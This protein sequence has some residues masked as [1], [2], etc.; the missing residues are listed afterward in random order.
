MTAASLPSAPKIKG[1]EF[2]LRRQTGVNPITGGGY[3]GATIGAAVWYASVETL[4]L[5]RAQA[6]EYAWLFANRRGSLRALY[7]YDASRP[8]PLAFHS[9]AWLDAPTCDSTEVTCDTDWITCDAEG[10]GVI[11]PWGTPRVVAVDGDAGTVDLEGFYPGAVISEGDYGAWDDGAT[12]R[13]H[14]THAGT[15][16]AAGALTLSVE[17]APPASSANLPAGFLM[18][19]ACAE[20]LLV[21]T[22]LAFSAPVT[23]RAAFEAIQV[24]RS[25]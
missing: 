18:E 8:R 22:S 6:G 2:S 7:I 21:R 24:L 13:L 4:E 15:A 17:A 1:G 11:A 25:Q 3:Q 23:S 16:N 19:K 10:D 12:R 14:I 9:A 5:S 20:M